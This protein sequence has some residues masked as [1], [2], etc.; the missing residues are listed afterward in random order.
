MMFPTDN[1]LVIKKLTVRTIKANKVRNIFVIIAIALTALLLS[2]IFSIGISGTESIQLQKIRTMGTI[3]HGGLTCPTAEQIKKLKSL[4]Y[5]KDVGIMAHAGEITETSE[6]GNLSLSLF[7]FDKTEWEKLRI[8][9]MSNIKGKYPQAYNEIMIPEWILKR[10]GITNPKIG[11]DI[12]I[13][14]VKPNRPESEASSEN[15]KLSAYYTEYSNLRSGNVGM[16]YVSKAFVDS[17]EIT[18]EKSGTATV[19]FKSNKNIEEQFEKLS[20]EV[21]S[22]KTQK[23]KTVP[24][25]ETDNGGRLSTIVGLSGLILFIMLSSYLLIYNVLYISVSKDVRFYGLLKT[26]G[27]TPRQIRKIVT[28]QATRL[29]AVGVPL[30]LALG[31]VVSFVAVPFALSGASIETGIK[32]S[33]NPII[34]VGA[35]IFSLVTTLISSIKPAGMAASISP[36]EAVRYTGTTVSRKL[37]KGST[38]GKVQ[39]MAFRNVFRNRRRAAVVFLSLFMGLTTFMLVNTLVLSMDT[40]NY[41]NSYVENDF[42]LTNNTF[43]QNGT[44]VKQKFDNDF[45]ST[46]KS[47]EGITEIRKVSQKIV[48]L[49]YDETLYKR[50]VEEFVKRFNS[51]MPTSEEMKKNPRIFWSSLVGLDT[52]Y[53]KKLNKTLKE[54]IDEEAFEDGRI[55]LFSTNNPKLFKMDSD[56]VFTA[57]KKEYSLKL[58]GFLPERT[59]FNGGTGLAPIVYISN[60]YMKKL[61]TDPVLCSITINS[62]GEKEANVLKQL[63]G[64]TA[65]D[66]EI[67]IESRLETLEQFKSS[68]SMLYILG[69]GISLILALIGILNFVNVMVTG[70]NTRRHEL[71]VLESIGM[72]SKQVKHMLSLEGLTYAIISCG[73][74]ATMGTAL[75]VWIFE[76]FKKQADYAIF[77]FPAIPLILFVAIVFAVCSLVPVAA[78]V[79]TTK[80][81]VTERLRSVDG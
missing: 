22:Y 23:W 37:I 55:A 9:A 11:M 14:Y 73:L 58:G 52:E 44:G 24:L 26:V 43:F 62:K 69:G 80:A 60:D 4:D 1:K 65:N 13:K 47:I 48:T 67:S 10:M 46:L 78:Y 33:F 27:T 63:K 75:N 49:K 34:Y 66:N 6:M 39:K 41:V 64:M 53:I 68:K 56:V 16:M 72:T 2:T 29:T 21:P 79:S 8:P 20:R 17:K 59:A 35:A 40:E 42:T 15:F 81:T 38:G 25:Y 31:A 54:P 5:I 51:P 18:P 12:Q 76:L 30:G 70:V 32:V 57:D 50:H 3:E 77:T 71:A 7:W 36:I 61:F 28:G 74:V 45:M 19:H